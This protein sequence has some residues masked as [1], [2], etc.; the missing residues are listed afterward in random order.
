MDSAPE[1][2]MKILQV[3]NR[4]QLPGGEDEVFRAERELLALMGHRVIEYVRRNDEIT[5]NG[6]LSS[7]WL[8]AETVWARDS[9]RALG[10]LIAREKP[11]VAH[12]HNTLPLVSPSAYYACHEAGVRVVQTLHNYRLACPAATFY[13]DGQVCEECVG[14]GLLRGVRH[15]CYRNSRAATAAVAAMLV[16][17]RLLDTWCKQVDCYIAPTEFSRRK[18]IEAGLPA[19]R[20][21][22]KPNFVHPDPGS[23]EG[24]GDYGL[25]VGRL[26][27]E[28]GLR[29]LVVA[30]R[31][32]GGRIP[33]HVVG[34]GP[35][36]PELEAEAG[37]KYL[38]LLSRLPREQTIEAIKGARFLVVPSEWYETFGLVAAEA[39]ACGVPVIA[40][41]LGAMEETV[42]DERTGLHFTPGDPDDLAAKVE[43]AWAHPHEMEAMGKE[44]RAEYEAKY[45]AERNY[46]LLMDIYARAIQAKAPCLN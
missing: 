18:F 4:Y 17:H 43:W 20:I 15:G 6:F 45:T 11:D 1:N 10:E 24:A 35:L 46:Q 38:Q 25:F 22:V 7:A 3:H 40:S 39:F 36:R 41:R 42:S 37:A 8:T 13:R 27:E 2:C 16:T 21:V 5:L 31:R 33:L 9:R 29:T 34:D 26:S 12:F 14:H 28:K 23:R 32:L 19:E 44:A 30:W